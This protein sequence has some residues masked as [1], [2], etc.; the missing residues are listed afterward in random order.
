MIEN[1]KVK[2]K[3]VQCGKKFETFLTPMFEKVYVP[4]FC[5]EKCLLE[6]IKKLPKEETRYDLNGGD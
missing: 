2:V 1:K 4:A 6:Y 3:C 5:S